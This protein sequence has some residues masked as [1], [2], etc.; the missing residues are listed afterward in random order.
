VWRPT[1][2]EQVAAENRRPEGSGADR[3][4]GLQRLERPERAGFVEREVGGEGP[5]PGIAQRIA[6]PGELPLQRGERPQDQEEDEPHGRER[7][8]A[9]P[10]G[11]MDDQ[12]QDQPHRRP[13]FDRGGR[14]ERRGEGQSPVGRSGEEEEKGEEAAGERQHRRLHPQRPGERRGGKEEAAGPPARLS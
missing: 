3:L 14:E 9:P 10:E 2:I 6:A 7:A 8:P 4:S 1:A 11:E 12:R 13:A 5:P